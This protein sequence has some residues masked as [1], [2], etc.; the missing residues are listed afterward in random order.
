M[1]LFN[2]RRIS[3]RRGY[4]NWFCFFVCLF[5]CL[6]FALNVGAS[7][8]IR[9]ISA[10]IKEETDSNTIIEE[11]FI[12]PLTPIYRLSRQKISKETQVLTDT[13]E[14]M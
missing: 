14:Q 2:D 1:S 9:Q 13:I 7:Q 12:T 11:D 5:V 10:A 3:P 6:F 8:Y 4:N